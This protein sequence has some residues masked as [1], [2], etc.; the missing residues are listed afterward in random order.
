MVVKYR[1]NLEAQFPLIALTIAF[2]RRSRLLALAA[3]QDAGDAL[4]PAG[5]L[6]R[7]LAGCSQP[8]QLGAM[9]LFMIVAGAAAGCL[10]LS[11]DGW[12]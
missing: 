11:V 2:A 3:H 7:P 10:T 1:L 9:L 6:R 4:R 5:W 8:G 12:I